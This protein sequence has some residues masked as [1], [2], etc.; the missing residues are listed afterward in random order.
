MPEYAVISSNGSVASGSGYYDSRPLDGS[1]AGYYAS[2]NAAPSSTCKPRRATREPNVGVALFGGRFHRF[3]RFTTLVEGTTWGVGHMCGGATEASL[4]A[5]RALLNGSLQ[6]RVTTSRAR[7]PAGAAA[8]ATTSRGPWVAAATAPA[9]ARDC[10]TRLRVRRPHCFSGA[11]LRKGPPSWKILYWY[12]IK[13]TTCKT[14]NERE[15]RGFVQ[16]SQCPRALKKR[17]TRLCFHDL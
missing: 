14:M 2:A 10:T 11:V 7:L 1:S 6:A 17:P 13:K 12:K 16:A 9:A 3:V 8:R 5:T 15:G 4:T